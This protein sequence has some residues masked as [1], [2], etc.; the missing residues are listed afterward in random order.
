MDRYMIRIFRGTQIFRIIYM[1]GCNYEKIVPNV[2]GPWVQTSAPYVN[3]WLSIASDST[4]QYL[5]ACGNGIGIYTNNNYGS[6]TWTQTSAPNLYWYSITS[7]SNGQYLAAVAYGGGIYTNNNYGS[8]TW[9]QTSAPNSKSWK[10]ITSNSTGQYLAAVVWNGMYT[11]N[12]YGSGTWTLT[13]APST[14]NWRS[15][16]SNSTGQYL[17]AGT[18]DNGGVY[19]NSNYGS[20][21]WTL[22]SVQTTSTCFSIASD[23]TGKYL[24]VCFFQDGIHTNSNYGSGTWTK[25]AAPNVR[26]GGIRC[27]S[28]GQ[29]IG[30]C[31]LNGGIYR[32]SN[33]GSGSWTKTTVQNAY[34]N[35]IASDSTG[36]YLA[37]VS[38]KQ[39]SGGYI[40]T[41]SSSIKI[42]IPF[43]TPMK[44]IETTHSSFAGFSIFNMKS[45]MS[46]SI[47]SAGITAFATSLSNYVYAG[48]SSYSSTGK[49]TPILISSDY[50]NTFTYTNADR[51]AAWNCSRIACNSTGQYVYAVV[52]TI[53]NSNGITYIRYSNDYGVTWSDQ[54]ANIYW[55]D[56]ACSV[57]GS[58]VVACGS[59][60]NTS[61]DHRIYIS[62]NDGVSWSFP[63]ITIS[64]LPYNVSISGDGKYVLYSGYYNIYMSSN[65]GVSYVNVGSIGGSSNCFSVINTNGQYIAFASDTSTNSRWSSNY[66]VTWD[67]F[68]SAVV[69]AAASNYLKISPSGK[70]MSVGL[71]TT[72]DYG[73]TWNQFPTSL[74]SSPGFSM[75]NGMGN[76]FIY[77]SNGYSNYLSYSLSSDISDYFECVTTT[78]GPFLNFNCYGTDRW[79]PSTASQ[80]WG[81]I[82]A[83]AS[84]QYVAATVIG[85]NIWRSSNYGSSWT[86]TNSTTSNWTGISTNSSGL[87]IAASTN[88]VSGRIWVSANAGASWGVTSPSIGWNG[89]DVNGT[90]Q[91]IVGAPVFGNLYVSSNFGTTWS[92]VISGS[93]SWSSVASSNSGLWMIASSTAGIFTSSNTGNTWASAY[94]DANVSS[95][96]SVCMSYS[97][98][99]AAAVPAS[100]ITGYIYMTTNYGTNWSA[101]TLYIDRWSSIAMSST[102]QFVAAASAIGNIY[103]SSNYGVDWTLSSAPN[104]GWTGVTMNYPGNYINICTPNNI[105]LPSTGS[106]INLTGNY[107]VHSFKGTTGTL[108]CNN[109]N[110]TQFYY[111]I[112]GGGGN[113]G[114]STTAA[115]V[116]GGGGGG[117]VLQGSFILNTSDTINITVGAVAS[118]SSISFTQNSNLNMTAYAGGNGGSA[119]S[120][121]GGNGGSGGGGGGAQYS[122]NLGGTGTTGQGYNGGNSD[123]AGLRTSGGGGGGAGGLGT[124]SNGGVGVICSQNGIS[125]VYNNV[126]FGGGGGGGIVQYNTR[127]DAGG[128]GGNGGGRGG[129]GGG[130][131]GAYGYA[132][133]GSNNA[134]NSG[135]GGGGA[136]YV[137]SNTTAPAT[138]GWSGIV[139][140]AYQTSKPICSYSQ[141][142]DLGYLFQST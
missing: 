107:I 64:N 99:Y 60:T 103:Q 119:T 97:G 127:Q 79:I 19:T 70:Y 88:S 37:S 61:S 46:I 100:T 23:S 139:V 109:P 137:S 112:V 90:G 126:Y 2:N 21:T 131:Y 14:V 101:K 38:S 95:W 59:S 53:Y 33:Y 102:G 55:R 91:Y 48:S 6:G 7:N 132:A 141:T 125:S 17:A 11:N 12:N 58:Y 111:L 89:V 49:T 73:M 136:A 13:S 41:T 116:G 140:I 129:G 114:A 52:D 65:Y 30:A 94:T 81:Q 71:L 18:E 75:S 43:E 105:M 16:T 142:M 1:S 51:G 69:I 50:G 78:P 42:V 117:G 54:V 118:N 86:N 34:W 133:S 8:G 24:V 25:T 92:N 80:N 35:S 26:W 62:R 93:R 47:Y 130:S 124:T 56:V 77:Y 31:A 110:I 128:S 113:G 63:A 134:P 5:A 29:Y 44:T 82:T 121:R 28:T 3:N 135:G 72:N 138:P 40:Y 98:Q 120:T 104:I 74:S 115:G 67:T 83:N 4:G 84:G 36:K 27:D 106:T 87:I 76:F 122:A 20:G 96:G 22:T 10:S 9:T 66:G 32:N 123:F 45:N 39:I 85:Q 15:I 57:S 68:P 108:T